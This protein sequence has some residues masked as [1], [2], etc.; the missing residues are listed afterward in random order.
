M[1]IENKIVNNLRYLAAA[2]I[3]EAN[4]GHT[5][6]ALGAAPI[7]YSVYAGGLKYS[8]NEPTYFNRDRFVLCAGHASAIY[9]ACLHAFGF[10]YSKSDLMN[11]RKKGS[12][13]KGHPSASPAHGID[14]SGGPLGQGI[15]MA[16]GMAIAEKKLADRFNKQGYDIINHHTI[17]FA[18]DG[19]MMEG[20]TNEASSLAGTLE[21]NK[22]IVL[23]DSNN[24]T[25]EGKTDIAFTENV[26]G[27][28]KA[29]GWNTMEVDNGEDV[30]A[31]ISAINIAKT[32]IKKPTIIKINT[33]IGFGSPYV[34]EAKIHGKALTKEELEVLKSKL[35]VNGT[36][37]E[38]DK[39]AKEYLSKI[40]MQKEVQVAKEKA[41]LEEYK[42]KYPSEFNELKLWLE[43]GYN[44]KVNFNRFEKQVKDEA[45]RN[46]SK[47]ILNKL[48][49]D[50]PNLISGS[51]D[52]AP[53]VGTELVGYGDF[54]KNNLSGRNIHFG[55]REHAMGAICN[56]I[57]LHGGFVVACST[58]MVFSDYMRHAIRMSA[59]MNLPIIYIL[60]HD[61][62]GVGED[63]K[64]HQPVE[65]NAMFR[66]MPNINFIRPADRFET[67]VAYK[68]ALSSLNPTILALSRQ[69]IQNLEGITNID[70]LKG[71]YFVAKSADEDAVIYSSGS[72]LA[73][74]LEAKQLL[75]KKGVKV[76]VVSVVSTSIFNRQNKAYKDKIMCHNAKVRACIEASNDDSWYKFV[77]LNG[78][79]ISVNDYGFTAKG[80]ELYEH[81]GITAKNLTKQILTKLK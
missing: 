61:S 70:A 25:I 28:Y 4:S 2:S 39:E 19:S 51:A 62:I 32:S 37:F 68:V 3:T 46:S 33:Q 54:S 10:D 57:A 66:A 11:F 16:V 36:D 47:Y 63:G 58:F 76:S 9:Y 78:V 72:E 79:V 69:N 56:G 8:P 20:I 75:E 42:N 74:A 43:N 26:L 44:E 48:A 50:I 13:T 21:L 38:L 23:Y 77:G 45:T 49:E 35:F 80:E 24:I 27:R 7:F 15:P 67:L 52:L 64:T 55:V 40:I 30:G 18:G 29:L 31:I 6:V 22:L 34:G 81:F 1:K 73:L 71:A 12:I 65:Y 14:A 60:S 5:G 53:S 41:K 59:L 17:V